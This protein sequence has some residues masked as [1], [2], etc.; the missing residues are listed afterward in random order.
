MERASLEIWG[1][2]LGRLESAKNTTRKE[3]FLGE[4]HNSQHNGEYGSKEDNLS[5]LPNIN[6]QFGSQ[7]TRNQDG[8][9]GTCFG[10]VLGRGVHQG[11][12][13]GYKMDHNEADEEFASN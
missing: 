6:F 13:E 5:V 1:A 9:D 7:P 10:P 8:N 12:P 11:L 3:N 2:S 4:A